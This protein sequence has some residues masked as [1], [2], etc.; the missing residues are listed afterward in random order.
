MK[1][2]PTKVLRGLAHVGNTVS[3]SIPL[4]LEQEIA[5]E[6]RKTLL[7]CGFGVGLSYASCICQR[8]EK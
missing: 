5:K 4:L 6:C 7:L 3:S 1:L 8:K 2:D